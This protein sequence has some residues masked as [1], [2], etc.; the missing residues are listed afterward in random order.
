MELLGRVHPNMAVEAVGHH[1]G[2]CGHGSL[3]AQPPVQVDSLT[4]GCLWLSG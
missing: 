2:L 3:G 4:H 1:R